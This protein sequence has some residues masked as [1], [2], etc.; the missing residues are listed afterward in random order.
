MF[1]KTS[2]ISHKNKHLCWNLFLLKACNFIKNRLQRRCFPMKF[3]K[4]LRALFSTDY[5]QWLLLIFTFKVGSG[6]IFIT[7]YNMWFYLWCV[8]GLTLLMRRDEN[9]LSIMQC[10]DFITA[11]FFSIKSEKQVLQNC[12]LLP[13]LTL[14]RSRKITLASILSFP[15]MKNNKHPLPVTTYWKQYLLLFGFYDGFYVWI[16]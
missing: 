6:V 9:M 12:F 4:F 8:R 15:R 14:I 5:L 11:A 3:A 16:L 10:K 2:Q 1:L 7:F 13:F